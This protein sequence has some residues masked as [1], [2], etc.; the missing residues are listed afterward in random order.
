MFKSIFLAMLVAATIIPKSIRADESTLS[1]DR[2]R[3][4]ISKALP[5]LEAGSIGSANKRQCFTCHSQ[6]VPVFALVEAKRHGF[7]VDEENLKRQLQHTF[8]HLKRGLANYRQGKGQG[9]D[10]L[11]AGY[12]LWTLD[13][14]NW[15]VDEVTEAVSRYLLETQ[16]E[17]R[18]WRHRGSRPPTSGSDFT[19]TYVALRALHHFGTEDQQEPI[20]ERRKLVAE[21]LA[22]TAPVETE[23][24]VFRLSSLNYVDC[25]PNLIEEAAAALLK[26]QRDDGGWGQ[27]GE[28]SSDAYATST[29]LTALIRDGN[30]PSS[31]EFILSGIAFL[32]STQRD[33]GTWQVTTRAKPVQEYFESDFP[34]G[35]DQF[36]SIAATA[37]STLA[38]LLVLP[39]TDD[40][41]AAVEEP[42]SSD[43]KDDMV[44][45]LAD[46]DRLV[47]DFIT[48]HEVPGAS[49]AMTDK[50][51]V[52]YAKGFGLADMGNKT[53]V[54]TSSLFRIASLSK[55]ITAV[56]I[57]QLVEQGK[58]R[59][60]DKVFS[61]LNLGAEILAVGEAF[62]ARLNDITIEHLL[63]H[64]GGWDRDQSF[65]P[66][67]Q[68]VRFATQLGVP[69]PAG[70]REVILAMLNQKL[71]FA[72]GE[73]YAYSNFGY[74]LLGRVIERIAGT[75][76]EAFVQERVLR[77]IGIH[78][79]HIGAT[80]LEDKDAAEVRYYAAGKAKSVFQFDLGDEVP[81]P[82][83][84]WNLEAMDSH[85][86][87][88]GTAEDI[89]KF[90]AS[91]DD[92]DHSP[93]LS[94]ENIE[95]MHARPI[96]LAGYAEGGEP[97]DSFY[98]LGWLNRVTDNGQINHWHTG[99]LP[100]T[101][102][103]M[104]RRRDG[105]NMVA[106]LNTR[107][108]PHSENLGQAIDK[109]LHKAANAVERLETGGN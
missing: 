29:A 1:T 12:A 54:Q 71:D 42:A 77:P 19:A 109:L 90:A 2:L 24:H 16:M 65:D 66:M 59:L 79:M 33:D 27:K 75:T 102:A 91:F 43:P 82:Y 10:V 57:L 3:A 96:G 38:L 53:S 62:D 50:G 76:Y 101:C 39:P 22:S 81:P 67:F 69:S 40:P 45:S 37:W 63:Q 15:P 70:H 108:S 9:G 25:D 80:R 100:G 107:D 11:T 83:G 78:S 4:S 98:S 94:R 41:Q 47:Q 86:G 64:R 93:I 89:A 68:S 17:L 74:C 73:R 95:R 31:N 56:A 32:L 88:I 46:V 61:V 97:K 51:K 103:I 92:L 87:W 28:M 104:I 13:E 6:A 35:K 8:N 23:D 21:W 105:R 26:T 99:S 106:L 72:P 58:L 14:G 48:K 36:I 7:S 34:H 18:H 52:V 5:T 30:I 85:G 44:S 49:I 20:A 60:D 84:S 55:P